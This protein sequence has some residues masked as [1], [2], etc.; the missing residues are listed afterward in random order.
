[1][2]HNIENFNC[3]RGKQIKGHKAKKGSMIPLR[4]DNYQVMIMRLI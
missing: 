3:C 1:M 4:K 2:S